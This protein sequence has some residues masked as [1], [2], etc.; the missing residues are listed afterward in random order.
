VKR[1]AQVGI[2]AVAI[3]GNK[4]QGARQRALGDFKDGKLHVLIATDIAARGIDIEELQL[5]INFDLP[6]IPETYVHRIGRTG[7][8]KASGIALSFCNLEE[9]AYLKDIQKLINQQIPVVEEHPF[10]L[11]ENEEVP[12]V[13]KPTKNQRKKNN[14]RAEHKPK[15]VETVKKPKRKFYSKKQR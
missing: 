5:V 15:E 2:L 7:R 4:S 14:R 6:N 11:D 10:L 9:K 13:E 8:A 12:L 3:H 1:L